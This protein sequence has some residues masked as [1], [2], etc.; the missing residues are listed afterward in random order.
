VKFEL[1]LTGCQFV[2]NKLDA[3]MT[4]GVSENIRHF[5]NDGFDRYFGKLV[6]LGAVLIVLLG[7]CYAKTEVSLAGNDATRFA[8]IRAVAEQNTFAIDGQV[9]RS[10][11]RTVIDGKVYSDK[12]PA[13]AL[14]IGLLYKIPHHL[15]GL[16]FEDHYGLSIYLVNF[17]IFTGINLA[18]YFLFFASLR[19]L[20]GANAIKFLFA[21]SLVL[22]SWLFSYSVVINNHTPAALL[23]LGWFL[24]LRADRPLAAGVLAGAALAVEIPVGAILGLTGGGFYLVAWRQSAKYQ[25]FLR[26]GAGGIGMILAGMAINYFGYGTVVP[27]YLHQNGGTFNIGGALMEKNLWEYAGETLV[28]NR[29][30]FSYQPLALLALPVLLGFNRRKLDTPERS[31]AAATVAIIVFYLIF[32]NE[33]GGWAYGFRYLIPILPALWYF[34]ARFSLAEMTTPI[35]KA[36]L[37]GLALVGLATA[38]V[39]SYAPFCVIYEGFRSPP[40][41]VTYQVRNSFAANLLAWSYENDPEGVLSRLL[42]RH[43]GEI[44]AK[45]YLIEAY[46]NLKNIDMLR[47]V[48]SE[49][50]PHP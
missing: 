28:G 12:P 45:R 27:L 37:I 47:Q 15:F 19:S 2:E 5:E 30:V 39:G 49:P 44:Q 18:L 8:V 13:P 10:V 33:Y 7:L 48:A 46:S 35:H 6:V 9:F 50:P 4:E 1:E 23:L 11:D 24:A 32:T 22:G 26:F 31:L 40:E 3:K 20:P 14:V 25:A 42:I 38:M 29:G 43:Y 36:M 41:T 21:L 17:F 16:N 34:A